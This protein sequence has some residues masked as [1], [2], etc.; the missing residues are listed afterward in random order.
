MTGLLDK[1]GLTE[2]EAIE[3]YQKK[4]YPKPALTADI[5]YPGGGLKF[6]NTNTP[7]PVELPLVAFKELTGKQL[8]ADEFTF[9]LKDAAGQVIQRVKNDA[10]GTA[11]FQNLQFTQAGV[12]TYTV[13]EENQ[14][15]SKVGYDSNVYTLTVTVTDDLLGK[16]HLQSAITEASFFRLCLLNPK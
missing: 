13:T 9:V 2:A 15:D 16:L 7:E 10:T 1:R 4:N 14:G 5:A 3:R 12:Y 11:T 6:T 8:Q